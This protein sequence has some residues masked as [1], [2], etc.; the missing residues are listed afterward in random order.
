MLNFTIDFLMKANTFT[1]YELQREFLQ[2]ALIAT[3]VRTLQVPEI[4]YEL[5]CVY[6]GCSSFKRLSRVNRRPITDGFTL[7]FKMIDGRVPDGAGVLRE[8][9]DEIIRITPD[10][11]YRTIKN[12]N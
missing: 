2:A 7:K 5:D 12:V 3:G 11:K 4:N 9:P 6:L 1:E 8:T 10:G